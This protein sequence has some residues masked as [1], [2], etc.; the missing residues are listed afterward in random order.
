MKLFGNRRHAAH[1]KKSTL[2]RGARTA[3]LIAAIVLLLSGTVARETLA[4]Q[5]SVRKKGRKKL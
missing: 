3:I 1:A 2:P 5:P 4:F